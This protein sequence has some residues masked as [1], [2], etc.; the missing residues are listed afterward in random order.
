MVNSTK[1]TLKISFEWLPLIMTAK[2]NLENQLA[3]DYIHQ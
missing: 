2:V 3:V 1:T